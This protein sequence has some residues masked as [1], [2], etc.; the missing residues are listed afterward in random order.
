MR[1]AAIAGLLIAAAARSQA[2]EPSP[3]HLFGA[4]GLQLGGTPEALH[5]AAGMGYFLK[6]YLSLGADFG[7][8]YLPLEAQARGGGN[9]AY[10]ALL[11]LTATARPSGRVAPYVVLGGGLGRYEASWT[12]AE[13]GTALALGAGLRVRLRPRVSLFVEARLAAIGGI[14]AADGGHLELPVKIG[15]SWSPGSTP[16]SGS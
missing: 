3:F 4:A 13:S 16:R 10:F 6:P 11:T 8:S 14:T 9:R 7:Y 15:V 12:K 5:L 1:A 2:A